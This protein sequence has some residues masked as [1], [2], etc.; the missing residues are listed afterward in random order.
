M[1]AYGPESY[2]DAQATNLLSCKLAHMADRAGPDDPSPIRAAS[3]A[4]SASSAMPPLQHIHHPDPTP[5]LP[6][7]RLKRKGPTLAL[8]PAPTPRRPN[9]SPWS[10]RMVK[11]V[12]M[13]I[14]HPKWAMSL[15]KKM[16]QT[17]TAEPEM[18]AK[19]MAM[20]LMRKVLA[21]MAKLLILMAGMKTLMG[22]LMNP[23]VRLKSQMLKA[24]PAL[25][26][27]MMKLKPKQ[28]CL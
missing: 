26:N 13:V 17:L 23:A 25:Q 18:T 16:K 4:G 7:V 19:A 9:L 6:F 1:F 22:K 24:T 15:R 14:Q 3:P 2:N 27:L 12:M 10:P 20:A 28:P 11:T 5:E 21:A 8:H